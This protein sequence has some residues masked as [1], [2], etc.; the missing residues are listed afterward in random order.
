[1]SEKISDS[2]DDSIQYTPRWARIRHY[3]REPFAEFLGTMILIL[4][5]DG[6]VAQVVLSKG[7][8]GPYQSISW[9][10]GVGVMLGVYV[11]GGISGGHINPGVTFANCLYRG[12]PWKKLPVYMAAQIL[13]GFVAAFIVYGNYKSAIDAYE[14]YNV[15]TVVGE[16]ASAGI[17]CTYPAPFLTRTGMFFSEI[18]ATSLLMLVIFAINDSNNLAAGPLAPLI[19]L[20]LIF[21]IGACFGWETGY[22][23]NTARDLG[24]RL[25]SYILGYGPEVWTA[26]GYYFWI[27]VV[28]P[29]LGCALG[30]FMYDLLIYT[31][32]ESPINQPYMGFRCLPK[33]VPDMEKDQLQDTIMPGMVHGQSHHATIQTVTLN[34]EG[35][36]IVSEYKPP[37]QKQAS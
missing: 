16:H 5:G 14:G 12:F 29:F 36:E 26:G 1:M 8:K 13:G 27:P 17:F 21:G 9:A 22:A 7:E 2:Y 33:K 4:F 6:V 25:A 3:L 11:S 28:C 30:G 24:P 20:F 34:N 15:R 10:W 37:S 18:V 32:S 35:H 31:G 23:M 19:L